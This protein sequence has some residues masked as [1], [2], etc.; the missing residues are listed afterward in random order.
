MTFAKT[1]QRGFSLA[2]TLVIVTLVGGIASA[3]IIL[4][5]NQMSVDQKTRDKVRATYL[6]E[7][8]VEFMAHLIR[9]AHANTRDMNVPTATGVVVDGYVLDCRDLRTAKAGGGFVD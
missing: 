7:A 9:K 1:T 8:G 3:L 5:T 2:T 4:S 6:A